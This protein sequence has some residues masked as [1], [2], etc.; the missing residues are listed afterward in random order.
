M[1][2][3]I[4]IFIVFSEND[5]S[6]LPEILRIILGHFLSRFKNESKQILLHR[7]W[8][9]VI[10]VFP[11][12]TTIFRG[13]I[14][15][16]GTAWQGFFHTE[17]TE[18]STWE[19][20]RLLADSGRSWLTRQCQKNVESSWFTQVLGSGNSS[21]LSFRWDSPLSLNFHIHNMYACI[22]RCST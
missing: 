15:I 22:R 16:I 10:P 21:S 20:V 12:P 2:Q 4:S 14:R 7:F 19:T 17:A 3:I 9:S 6:V 8:R 11:F 13:L 18:A 1:F 5:H